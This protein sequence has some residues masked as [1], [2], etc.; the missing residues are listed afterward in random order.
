[1][2]ENVCKRCFPL[3]WVNLF[4]KKF[5]Q[6]RCH[7]QV[8]ACYNYHP[9]SVYIRDFPTFIQ[10][11][12]LLRHFVGACNN[13]SKPDYYTPDASS[14]CLTSLSR[15]QSVYQIS[16]SE[17]NHSY[18]EQIYWMAESPAVES[19]FEFRQ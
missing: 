10:L 15:Y 18:N 4:S 2:A 9:H 19:E 1:M 11:Q 13:Y 12:E 6:G 7:I 8:P 14:V 5:L 17:D 16:P 3:L